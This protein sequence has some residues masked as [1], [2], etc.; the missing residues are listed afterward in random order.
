MFAMIL[1]IAAYILAINATYTCYF[2]TVDVD[3]ITDSV[4]GSI[5]V[6]LFSYQGVDSDGQSYCFTYTQEQLES[7]WDAPFL[8]AMS[9]AIIANVTIG[10]SMLLLFIIG[11]YAFEIKVLKS[12]GACSC[13]GGLCMTLTFVAY[14]SFITG[15]PYNARFSTASGLAI[16]S[17]VI[18]IIS[19]ALLWVA[20]PAEE[21]EAQPGAPAFAP[22]TETTT[23]TVFP[24]GTKKI[25]TTKVNPDGSRSVTETVEQAA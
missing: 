3:P 4:K 17:S 24:D 9:F 20:P 5:G 21:E 22:G 25:V 13:G 10:I 16:A 2:W 19:A 7:I 15:P 23:E 8:T 12:M 18:A 1:G 11:C 6:G 14:S